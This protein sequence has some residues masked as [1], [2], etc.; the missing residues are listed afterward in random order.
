VLATTMTAASAPSWAQSDENRAAAR[1]IGQQG[2]QA[3]QEKRWADAVDLFTRAESL[4]PAPTFEL[5][6]ARAY[7]QQGKL[8]KAQEAYT[9]L[10]REKLPQD[11]PRPFVDAQADA[12]RELA[13]LKPRLASVTIQVTGGPASGTSVTMDGQAVP[14]ALVGVAHPVDPGQHQ[15]QATAPGLDSGVVTA[16]LEE[17]ASKTV[18]LALHA[19]TAAVPAGAPAPAPPPTPTSASTAP[20]STL[21]GATSAPAE[22]DSHPSGTPTT[23]YLGFGSL[24]LAAVGVGLGVYFAMTSHQ[25][26]SDSSAL[27]PGGTCTASSAQQASSLHSQIN[28]LNSDASTFGALSVTSF[29]VG[30]AAAAAGVALLVLSGRRGG[31]PAATT[32]GAIEITPWAGPGSA[33]ISGRF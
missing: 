5:Y 10:T 27:C 4:V 18:T 8:V 2:V 26:E 15:M 13:A 3:M 31:A 30:G 9:R 24:G 33:G 29:V 11:A 1:A 22:P 12:T 19:G 7:A 21:P 20:E 17:G 16:T 6:L 25:K 14:A 28:S 23:R 32:T